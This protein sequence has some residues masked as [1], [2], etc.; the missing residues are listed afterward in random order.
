V[1]H[2]FDSIELAYARGTRMPFNTTRG[3]DRTQPCF[4]RCQDR[5][6]S[7]VRCECFTGRCKYFGRM[8]SVIPTYLEKNRFLP[9][10]IAA[11]RIA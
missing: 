3:I 4:R 10:L 6:S 11:S 1:Q 7:K 2:V 9:E 5:A 8:T